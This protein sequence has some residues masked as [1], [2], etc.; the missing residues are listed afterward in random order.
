MANYDK[1]IDQTMQTYVDSFMQQQQKRDH[2]THEKLRRPVLC[3]L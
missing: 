1:A 3:Y 2:I